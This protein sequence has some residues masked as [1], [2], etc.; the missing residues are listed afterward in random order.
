MPKQ[1]N[2]LANDRERIDW[3]HDNIENL[4]A[5][6]REFAANCDTGDRDLNDRIKRLE[7][8]SQGK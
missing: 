3:L 7:E 2:D 6:M 5:Q 8:T 1:W 4:R